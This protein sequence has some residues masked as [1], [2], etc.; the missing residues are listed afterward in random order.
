MASRKTSSP[1]SAAVDACV[2]RT[3]IGAVTSGVMVLT[4]RDAAGAHAMT[5]SA[6]CSLTMELPMLLVCAEGDVPDAAG[7]EGVC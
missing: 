5:I 2:Y 1:V 3:V 4:A 6:V 7:A